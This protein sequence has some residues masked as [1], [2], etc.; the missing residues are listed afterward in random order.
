MTLLKFAGK[1][2]FFADVLK[3]VSEVAAVKVEFNGFDVD[4]LYSPVELLKR[5]SGK[6]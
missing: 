4:L 6:L 5:F 2:R 3:P 1:L